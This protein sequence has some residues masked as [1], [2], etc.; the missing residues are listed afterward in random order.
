MVHRLWLVLV[1][2]TIT[3]PARAA[4][5]VVDLSGAVPAGGPDHFFLPFDVPA[6]IVEV[7]IQ[8]DDLSS[9]NI[10]D[11]GLDDPN[12]TRGWGG[13][14]AEPAIVGVQ[15]ASRGYLAGPIPP[16]TWRVVVGKAKV[17]VTPA[18]FSVK[19]ILR[20]AAT[21]APQPERTPY[22][23]APA[24]DDKGGWYAGDFH[25]HS[26]ESGDAKPTLDEIAVFAKGRGLDF[27]LLSEHNTL[28]QLD[29]YADALQK[30]P[31]FLFLP[32][33]EFTTYA[34]HANA[35]GATKWVDHR[36]GQPG[37]TIGSAAQAF[38]NQ[39]ALLSINHPTL[40][41]G[42]LCI[43]CGWKHD[44]DYALVDAVEIQTS[45]PGTLGL[46]LPASAVAWWDALCA[47]GHHLA[48]LGGSDDH[49]A[50]V[51]LN[52][53]Q[54][55]I[56]DPTTMVR[57]SEL[58]TAAIIEGV[59]NG[60]TVVKLWGP[61]EPMIEL[62]ASVAPAGDTVTAPNVTFEAKVSGGIGRSVRFVV[63]GQPRDAVSVATD[64]FSVTLELD[65]P[66]KGEARVRAE[67]LESEVLR[68]ITSHLWLRAPGVDAGVDAGSDAGPG[69]KPSPADESS[70]CGCRVA[71]S[72]AAPFGWLLTM[73]WLLG[74]R[75]RRPCVSQ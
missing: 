57:A 6:G 13:G 64:P 70:S 67:V 34:G 21:L 14:N 60:R 25:V 11:F 37:V 40:D 22:T 35:I 36:I 68:T 71:G 27:V 46:I 75:R 41:I 53:F 55:P 1:A 49:R 74:W 3:A 42:D 18:N 72:P 73:F 5:T 4:E 45:T 15:A 7:E 48:A 50:G 39:G 16:G 69:T 44:L 33:M 62:A 38:R 2:L 28:S 31:D 29:F 17:Q 32:G 10:L 52:A 9:E 58:S 65:A 26:R 47:K 66:A 61:S 24:I 56:G 12:G 23:P 51:G 30:H 20:D 8:H 19:A 54:S 63:D 43:G 59:K